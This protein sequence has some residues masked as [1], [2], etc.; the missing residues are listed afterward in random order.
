[1]FVVGIGSGLSTPPMAP[2]NSN[3]GYHVMCFQNAELF[4]RN[5][6]CTTIARQFIGTND[7]SLHAR[8]HSNQNDVWADCK[9][10]RREIGEELTIHD[11]CWC[12]TMRNRRYGEFSSVF[13]G[14]GSYSNAC[15]LSANHD[16]GTRIG[17]KACTRNPT[18]TEPAIDAEELQCEKWMLEM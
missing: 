3:A 18:A 4:I 16:V 11:G 8:H 13:Q 17:V 15:Q 2:P 5:R 12:F 1:M 7:G 9:V 14:G 6:P 10:R